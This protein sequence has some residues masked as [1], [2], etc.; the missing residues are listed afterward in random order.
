MKGLDWSEI[1]IELLVFTE[2]F[3]VHFFTENNT[4]YRIVSEQKIDFM[5]F[6]K[7]FYLKSI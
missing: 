2:R 3:T 4:V 5:S 1:N 7:G 6:G